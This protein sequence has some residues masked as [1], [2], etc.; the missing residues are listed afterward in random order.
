MPL[1]FWVNGV[2]QPVQLI[3]L[4]GY[5]LAAPRM[6]NTILVPPAGER[7]LLC[8]RRNWGERSVRFDG[9]ST[10]PTGNPDLEQV[11]ANVELTGSAAASAAPVKPAEPQSYLRRQP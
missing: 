8:R 1:Q 7:N 11:L 2:A 4:D 9:Y 10:G 3:A 5:P 6:L